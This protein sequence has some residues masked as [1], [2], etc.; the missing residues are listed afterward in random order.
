LCASH[1]Y[2]AFYARAICAVVGDGHGD[3][4][5]YVARE[6]RIFVP[7]TTNDSNVLQQDGIA[8]IL[9]DGVQE[10]ANE[11]KLGH[12]LNASFLGIEIVH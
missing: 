9:F 7:V 4:R 11:I 2:L 10:M 1:S 3:L 8:T 6:G 12:G 5:Q